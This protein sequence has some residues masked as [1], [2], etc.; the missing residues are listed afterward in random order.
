MQAT[1]QTADRARNIPAYVLRQ[2]ATPDAIDL[3]EQFGSTV[4][5]QREHGICGQGDA[6]DYCWRILSGCVRTVKLMEDGRRQVA[7]FLFPGDLLGLDDLG[8]HDFAAEAVTEVKLRRYPR[9]MVE[10]LADSH[11]ALA[12]RLRALALANLRNAHERMIMLGRKTAVEKIASFVLEMDRRATAPG[13]K[14][15]EIPMSRTDVAD[16]LGLTVETVCRILAHMKRESIVVLHRS[17]I[18]VLDRPTLR[19]MASEPRH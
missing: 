6:A 15:T 13:Q 18:E 17:G 14:V 11:T 5:V 8:T 2:P 9:R 1:M 19:A 4:T 16:H 12:R 3:L 7:D 10:A